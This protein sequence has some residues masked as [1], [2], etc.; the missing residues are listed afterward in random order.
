MFAARTAFYNE[1]SNRQKANEV[2]FPS[3]D[4]D[5]YTV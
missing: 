3:I 2:E 5:D 4:P 1:V